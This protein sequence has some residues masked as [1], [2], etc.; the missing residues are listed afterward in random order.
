MVSLGA[1]L[2]SDRKN[3]F[4]NTHSR[5]SGYEAY[6]RLTPPFQKLAES[7]TATHSQP[8]FNRTAQKYGTQLIETEPGAPETSG[9]DFNASHP[10]IRTNPVTGWKSLYAAGLQV[11]EGCID[12]VAPRESEMLKQYFLDTIAQNHDLQVRFRWGVNDLAIWDK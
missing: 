5:A 2:R 10:V 11:R 7:L 6:D 3:S 9:L 1:T 4:T 12:G 8:E